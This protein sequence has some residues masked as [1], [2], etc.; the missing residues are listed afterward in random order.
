MV[1]TDEEQASQSSFTVRIACWFADG[2]ICFSGAEHTVLA[3]MSSECVVVY[4][5]KIA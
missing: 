5:G 4:I 3:R 1:A 2:P